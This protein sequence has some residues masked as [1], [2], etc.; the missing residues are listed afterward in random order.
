MST[1]GARFESITSGASR[2]WDDLQEHPLMG[3]AAIRAFGLTK[4]PMLWFIRPSVVELSAERTVIKV[5]LTRRTRNHLGVMYVGALVAGADMTAGLNAMRRIRDSGER[6]HLLFKDLQVDFLKR[7]DHDAHFT[8]EDGHLVRDAVERAVTTA[9]RVNQ[10]VH[11][12]T[13]VP[14]NL[15]T[16]PVARFALTLTLK[17]R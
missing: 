11:V 6:V 9:E 8:C 1:L 17:K 4:I 5:P 13:T 12:T 2:M 15:G 10:T 16:E 14:K 3:T 7:V